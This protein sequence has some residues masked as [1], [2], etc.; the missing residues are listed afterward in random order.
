MQGWWNYLHLSP[1]FVF[2]FQNHRMFLM[3]INDFFWV[4]FTTYHLNMCLLCL[5]DSTKMYERKQQHPKR[6]NKRHYWWNENDIFELENLSDYIWSLK[7]YKDLFIKLTTNELWEN[8]KHFPPLSF[9]GRE[10]F[11]KYFHRL[12]SSVANF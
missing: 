5:A 3:I 11:Q 4:A 2:I 10:F 6:N 1:L 9:L 8:N 7:I 12:D